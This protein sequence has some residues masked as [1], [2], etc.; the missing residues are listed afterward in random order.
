MTMDMTVEALIR[1]LIARRYP[2]DAK[3]YIAIRD[4]DGFEKDARPLMRSVNYV[5]GVV[6]RSSF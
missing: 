4:E 5:G 3:V 6:A 2:L 1:E